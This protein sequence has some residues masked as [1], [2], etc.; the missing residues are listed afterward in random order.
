[1]FDIHNNF[2]PFIMNVFWPF[3]QTHFMLET[4]W[5]LQTHFV[6]EEAPLWFLKEK[7]EQSEG[8]H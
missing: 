6:L 5:S 1:V 7:P 4:R 3:V 2:H 8:D